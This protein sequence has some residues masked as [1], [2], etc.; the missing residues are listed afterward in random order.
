MDIKLTLITLCGLTLLCEAI[1]FEN[2]LQ[3]Q[4][5]RLEYQPDQEIT[6]N[7]ESISSE[8]SS[9][10]YELTSP[11]D[12]CSLVN[13][14]L[15]GAPP[16]TVDLVFE[17]NE[18][19][20][21]QGDHLYSI[22]LVPSS[23]LV[24][25]RIFSLESSRFPRMVSSVLDSI[26]VQS[27]TVQA[28]LEKETTLIIVSSH[29]LFFYERKN[30]ESLAFVKLITLS[31]S[32]IKSAFMQG[33]YLIALL[34]N[35]LIA[36]N[37]NDTSETLSANIP[38][39]LLNS[40][41]ISISD[42]RQMVQCAETFYLV[43]QTQIIFVKFNI[44][45]N[46]FEVLDEMDLGLEILSLQ[47][48]QR[49]VILLT[50]D[51]I[52]EFLIYDNC[53]DL[54][55]NRIF[56]LSQFPNDQKKGVYQIISPANQANSRFFSVYDQTTSTIYILQHSKSQSS[57]GYI[58]YSQQLNPN[59]EVYQIILSH[60]LRNLCFIT[61]NNVWLV[62]LEY[63]PMTLKCSGGLGKS[64]DATVKAS[65]LFCI[66]DPYNFTQFKDDLL[67]NSTDNSLKLQYSDTY[68]YN[69]TK[70]CVRTLEIALD[71][72]WP[73]FMLVLIGIGCVVVLG[74]LIIFAS[75]VR[76]N[77]SG[78]NKARRFTDEPEGRGSVP[79]V[80]TQGSAQTET[81]EV[82]GQD[83]T[84]LIRQIEMTTTPTVTKRETGELS[85]GPD[86][87][88][89]AKRIMGFAQGKKP[90]ATEEITSP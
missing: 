33:T 53:T 4:T 44:Q 63:T 85:F 42:I 9:F 55:E 56:I 48:L 86:E 50:K 78:G 72:P 22:S 79:G 26:K 36:Y 17:K 69:P 28:V 45:T 15:S 19:L 12:G 83:K 80:D 29:D 5:I 40:Q 52:Y 66:A 35:S 89:L 34:S 82:N 76:S 65:G 43:L 67:K 30:P 57:T 3:D 61:N 18:Y 54:H 37:L 23:D 74:C 38:S 20:Y 7:L 51:H 27:G 84:N 62:S 71:F 87:E 49:A 21:L 75:L 90:S 24:R 32:P 88:D 39:I 2:Q 73:L 60:D 59:E 14:H 16:V 64:V 1:D 25:I 10:V 11:V 77:V 46:E 31:N 6:L 81:H 47:I 70:P 13:A 68:Y 8:D 41:S 58:F